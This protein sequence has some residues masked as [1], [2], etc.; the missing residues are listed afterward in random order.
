MKR[1]EIENL[2]QTLSLSQGFY[3]RLLNSIYSA[4][5]DVQNDY[6]AYMEEQ[7]FGDALDVILFVEG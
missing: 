3:G 7:N 5:E 6:W 4:P 2:F 1:H